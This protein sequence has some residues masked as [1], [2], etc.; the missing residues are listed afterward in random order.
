MTDLGRMVVGPSSV[1]AVAPVRTANLSNT[2]LVIDSQRGPC[3]E[4]VARC[5]GRLQL[6]LRRSR[7]LHDALRYLT[8][9]RETPDDVP[10]AVVIHA[11]TRSLVGIAER[12]Y[13]VAPF[14]HILF[15]ADEDVGTQLRL[16]LCERATLRTMRWMISPPTDDRLYESLSC[17]AQAACVVRDG[18]P[19]DP[20]VV[21][22]PEFGRHPEFVVTEILPQMM[23]AARADGVIDY[24]NRRWCLFAGVSQTELL[25]LGWQAFVHPEDR[26]LACAAWAH[27]LK[28]GGSLDIEARLRTESG[29]WQ[30]HRIQAEPQR[31]EDAVTRW[32]GT[33]IASYRRQDIEEPG[34]F[35][36]DVARR[37]TENLDYESTLAN[38]AHV[39]VPR[40][41]D[42]CAVD[43]VGTSGRLE[44]MSV[45]HTDPRVAERIAAHRPDTEVTPLTAADVV[46]TGEMQLVTHID[47]GLIDAVVQ[48]PV[49]REFFA[50]LALRSLLR[51]PLRVSGRTVGVISFVFS[52]PGTRRYTQA[53]IPL[54]TEIAQQGAI[55]VE[56]ARLY[57]VAREELEVR[58]RAEEALA[59]SEARYRS[60]MEAT[61][62]I[63]WILDAE[64]NA[65][66]DWVN[67]R[68]FT[69]QSAAEVVGRGWIEALAPVDRA[70]LQGAFL[71]NATAFKP[72][73]AEVDLVFHG[74]GFRRVA[75]RIVPLFDALGQCREWIA[76]GTDITL[77][78]AAANLLQRE[79][80]QLAVTL[81]SLGEAVVTT[82]IEGRIVL[83]NRVA[84]TLT[85]WPQQEVIG[86]LLNEV[87][88]VVD[89]RSR[90]PLTD[91]AA[92]VLKTGELLGP[93]DRV[94]LRACDG[95]ERIVAYTAAPIRDG[96][97][98]VVGAVIVFRDIT[99]EHKLE[100][101]FLKAQKLES[102]GVLAG[103]IAHDFNNI[104]TAVIG[105]IALAKMYTGTNDRIAHA[106]SEAEKAAWRAR[107]LTQQ[108]L[109]FAKGGAPVRRPGSLAD[110]LRE[111]VPFALAGSNVKC[112]LSIDDDLW[113]LAFDPGQLSQAV[114]N[115]VI[116]ATQA[117]PAGGLIH[118][119]AKNTELHD[120]D[121]VALPAGRYVRLVVA[122]EGIGIARDHLDKIF[123]PYFTTKEGQTGLGLAT[124][125]S[126]IHR[127]EGVIQVQSEEG[128]G[129]RFEILL[130]AQGTKG[131]PLV[132]RA[133]QESHGR[134]LVMDDEVSLLQ[135]VTALLSRLGYEVESARDGME[136]VTCYQ[137]AMAQNRPFA[138]VILDLTVPAG[139]GGEEC[140][141]H[142]QTMDPSVCAIVSSGYYNDPIIANFERFGF[143]GAITK[144]YQLHDL[145]AAIQRVIVENGERLR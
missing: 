115:L 54:A 82:D 10:L 132:A 14:V 104:L 73:T 72:L 121:S 29:E 48:N 38:L 39:V 116:N 94:I 100:E 125:Y 67:W 64:G 66:G 3:F 135:V 88:C 74:G 46:R 8:E 80:E 59:I 12:I 102:V 37:V 28:S 91:P 63:V 55:A 75:M 86:H 34:Q 140:L 11:A 61:T 7:S 143:R 51:I 18:N 49:Q 45:A 120:Q 65:R 21:S 99:S 68:A 20:G 126:I 60:L 50:S 57:R 31:T 17:A 98:Q 139:M 145:N 30:W 5:V 33:C 119:Q 85:G 43:V 58:K 118:I 101:D 130:P 134:I 62:Q 129:T 108:F 107:G 142:L 90:V 19:A 24:Y 114:N 103:G 144:P 15:V 4:R 87:F 128:R 27:A 95:V 2:I 22:V 78:K 106:L 92:R 127:H 13:D 124:A 47:Q 96:A 56:N 52:G 113:T 76:A 81:N 53:D 122:D 84:Q 44:R 41:A 35:L 1:D 137:E 69:G 70:K 138:A 79:K 123:D 36:S 117:M 25:C 9:I 112:T 141:R 77:K 83:F 105:N 42:W 71:A 16:R 111:A 133:G 32:F 131:V 23:W 40:F 109:T 97:S 136:A 110:L 93:A 89:A 6:A 26:S